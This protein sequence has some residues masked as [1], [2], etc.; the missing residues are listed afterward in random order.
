MGEGGSTVEKGISDVGYGPGIRSRSG[1]AGQHT[2]MI[3][4]RNHDIGRATRYIE[5]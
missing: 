2:K 1:Q 3:S 4:S 5:E